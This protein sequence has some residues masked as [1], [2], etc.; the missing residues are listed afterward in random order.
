MGTHRRNTREAL[1]EGAM[2]LLSESSRDHLRRVFTAGA[3]AESAGVHRQTFYLHWRNQAEFVDDFVR[4]VMDPSHSSSERLTHIDDDLEDASDDP[5]A[6]VRRMSRRTYTSWADDPVHFARMVLW[7][8]H[9]N[10][11][12]VRE[13]MQRLYRAN[14]AAAA[15]GFA[16]V[17]EAWGIE[18]RPPFTIET[19]ALLFNALRDG[20]MLQ[21]MIRGDEIPASFFGDVHLA[22][23][24]M[25]T[26][27]VG[28]E[29][30]PTLD[31]AYR[32]HVRGPAAV[33]PAA[34]QEDQAPG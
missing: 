21:L 12:L 27:R 23:S 1:L 4:Y 20:L 32:A 25:V 28:E 2:R 31:D 14:D 11:E 26:R 16:A 22:M 10:D 19:V 24:R 5:A 29:D 8:T 34:E 17:G 13:C 30:T 33:A 18:P 6:E 9:P 15:E 3:V 7:A